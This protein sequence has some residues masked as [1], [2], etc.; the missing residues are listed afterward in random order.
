MDNTIRCVPHG[1]CTGCGACLNKCPTNAISME[2]DSEG[3][4]F[5]TISEERCVHCGACLSVC[6][7]NTP[8][9][10]YTKPQIY[11]VWADEETRAVS[12]SGGMF[13]VLANY[14]L[15]RGGAVCGAAYSENYTAVQ[16]I[17]VYSKE[18]LFALRGSKYVQSSTGETFRKAKEFLDQGRMVLYSGCPCQI[19]GLRKYLGR[20]DPN[21]YLADIVCHGAPSPQVYRDYIAEKSGGGKIERMDFREKSYWGWGTATSLF[22]EGGGVYRGNCYKDPYW[23]GFLSGVITR[24]CCGQCPYAAMSRIGDFTIGDFWGVAEIDPECDDKKGTSLVFLNT[25]KAEKLFSEL[26]PSL[27]LAK[28][29]RVAAVAEL[30]KTRNGQLCHPTPTHHSRARFFKLSSTEPFSSAFERALKFDVG[31]V[32]WWDSKNY[33]SSLTCYAMNRTLQ[34]MGKSVVMLEHPGMKPGENLEFS[35]GMQFARKFYTCSKITNEKNFQRFNHACDTFLVGSDQLWNWWCNKDMGTGYFFLDFVNGSHKKIAYAASFGSDQTAY[36][37]NLR[38]RIGYLMSR[39]DSVSVREESGVEVCAQEFNIAAS[40]VLDPVFLCDMESYREVIALS[41]KSED[42][43]YL[44][45]YILDPTEDKLNLIRY[46]AEKLNLPYRI[47]IDALGNQ[48]RI[49]TLLQNDPNILVDLRI[50]DWLWYMGNCSYVVTDSFHGFS[51]SVI[52]KKPMIAYLNAYR[53]KARFDS[54]TSAT[55]LR[56]RLVGSFEEAKER[57]LWSVSVDFDAVEERMKEKIEFSK[58]WLRSALEGERVPTSVKELSLWKILEH[59]HMIRTA[60]SADGAGAKAS[61]TL[62]KENAALRSEIKQLREEAQ[63]LRT[64]VN[65]LSRLLRLPLKL[66]AFYRRLRGRG[67]ADIARRDK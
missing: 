3:F 40:W 49:R 25:P 31:Y 48:E 22:W 13:S 19:A 43:P 51:F 28:K 21:L 32:G 34:K 26:K 50:E 64:Q 1:S 52:F 27:P 55:G 47:A 66:Q 59:D 58:A 45:A 44:F 56:D 38:L 60:A 63:A 12:S 29:Q 57:A 4:L 61:D 10:L 46:T 41:N 14:V 37:E 65:S 20:D 7:A 9:S 16:H 8:I 15:E 39:F 54:I 33:G 62:L 35:F 23:R 18:E 11:A 42:A 36:P 5:P 17:W 53:G 24:E 30:A 67:A 6:P 2:Q